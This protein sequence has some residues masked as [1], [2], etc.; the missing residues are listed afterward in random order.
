MYL[1]GLGDTVDDCGN[2]SNHTQTIVVRDTTDPD[3]VCNTITIFL[4]AAGNHNLTQAELDA[5][6]AGSDDNCD[7]V[8]TY[9]VDQTFFD[10]SDID[11]DL[12]TIGGTEVELTVVDCSGNDATCT[13]LV[14]IDDSAVPFDFG[15]IEDLNVTL[16]DQCSALI[17]GEMVITGFRE[18]VDSYVIR[19]DGQDTD[20][21]T[22]LW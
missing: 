5:I 6:A 16:G 17:T 1:H 13:A 4:D 19:I 18:C 15:C 2:P 21:L 20:V 22:G 14:E 10:C 11:L 9:S 12:G 3:P 8:F 7:L